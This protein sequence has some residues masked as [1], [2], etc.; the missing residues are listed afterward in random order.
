MQRRCRQHG[1]MWQLWQRT[2]HPLSEATHEGRHT[3][4]ALWGTAVRRC[5]NTAC[6]QCCRFL[7]STILHKCAKFRD[8]VFLPPPV[9]KFLVSHIK[10]MKCVSHEPPALCDCKTCRLGSQQVNVFSCSTQ[11]SWTCHEQHCYQG[12]AWQAE[13]SSL[14]LL[15]S[16][17]FTS[18][19]V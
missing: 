16:T 1:A 7:S 2:P 13:W 15:V 3:T 14:L 5:T 4:L 11:P 12:C 8:L 9:Y 18:P 10:C 17:R 6:L 19:S